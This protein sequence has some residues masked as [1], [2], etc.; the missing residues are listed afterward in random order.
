MVI[1]GQ[2]MEATKAASDG[3][4]SVSAEVQ[5]NVRTIIAAVTTLEAVEVRCKE[6]DDIIRGTLNANNIVKMS[7]Q[8]TD[9]LVL[10]HASVQSLHTMVTTL[11]ADIAKLDTTANAANTKART[12][13]DVIW[14]FLLFFGWLVTTAIAVFAAFNS[15]K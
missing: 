4:K 1:V 8:H 11:K 5:N 2:L 7:Q 9:Q 14:T 15:G 13:K 10:L 12:T 6:I 3:L